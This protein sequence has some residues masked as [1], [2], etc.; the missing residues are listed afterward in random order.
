VD[1]TGTHVNGEGN[2]GFCSSECSGAPRE[3]GT[4]SRFRSAA[5][6]SNSAVTFGGASASSRSRSS[7]RPF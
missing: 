3:F 7:R 5:S 2:Y 1:P 4:V 6:S